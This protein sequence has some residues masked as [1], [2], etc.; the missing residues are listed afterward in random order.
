[1]AIFNSYV[2]HYQRVAGIFQRCFISW[3]NPR[4][5]ELARNN[6]WVMFLYESDLQQ[7]PADT[8]PWTTG[9]QVTGAQQALMIFGGKSSV[10]FNQHYLVGGLEMFGTWILFFHILG[11]ITPTDSHF[12]EGFKPASYFF[13][14]VF[15]FGCFSVVRKNGGTVFFL[16]HASMLWQTIIAMEKHTHHF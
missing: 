13:C 10:L 9:R 1:M 7:C 8:V 14:V 6:D 16:E 3:P 12:S 11:I 5:H 4:L 2:S 15:F